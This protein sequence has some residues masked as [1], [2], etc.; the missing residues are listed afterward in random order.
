[1]TTETTTREQLIAAVAE[2]GEAVMISCKKGT[3]AAA[4]RQQKAATKLLSLAGVDM[5][6]T[7]EVERCIPG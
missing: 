4:L 6:T 1:M 5:P 3:F 2:F 7:E